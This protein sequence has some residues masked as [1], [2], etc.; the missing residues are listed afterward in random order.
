M[1]TGLTIIVFPGGANLPLWTGMSSAFL[2][3]KASM[4]F[5]A[6]PAT[7]SSRWPGWLPANGTSA[8]PASTTSSPTR[9]G[10]AR[11]SSTGS[12]ICSP[13]WAGTTHSSGSSCRTDI[14]SYADLKGKTLSVDALTTGFAFVLRKMLQHHGIGENEVAFE[15][16]G[17]V[18]Q[19]FEAL[20]AGKHAGTLLLTPLE[21]IAAH[22]GLRVLQS[23]SDVVP[24]YQ[25]IVG[26]ARSRWAEANGDRLVSFIKG[27][28]LALRWLFEPRNQRGAAMSI[29][30]E[31]A[32]GMTA[33]IAAAT[34]EVFSLP[35]AALSLWRASTLWGCGKSL[36]CVQSS[37]GRKKCSQ[38]K[39]GTEILRTTTA[40][41][42]NARE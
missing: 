20:K 14:R 5:R 18:V 26:V 35:S 31:N 15:S 2:R 33:E 6:I 37:G 22:A 16:A 8:S 27:Y 21:L 9:K 34:C 13:S 42:R 36:R 25:G 29:L 40:R 28:L 24:H 32:P 1:A 12:R 7:R 38:M 4:S 19:R 41:C 39:T 11:R 3:S 23:A 17:G 30:V 10:R